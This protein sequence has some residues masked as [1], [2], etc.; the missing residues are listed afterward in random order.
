MFALWKKSCDK[1]RQHIKKQRHHFVDKSLSRQSYDFSRSHVQMW[2]LD[3]KEG[4]ALKNWCF[5]TEG[6]E[7]TL[8]IPWTARRSNQSTL[9]EINHEYLLKGLMQKLKLQHFGHLM[10]RANW[11]EKKLMLGN[12]EGRRRRGWQKMRW[13]DG[14]ID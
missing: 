3:H 10:Q 4:W 9:K 11:L 2:D 12:I 6:L 14:I 1:P 8:R 13:L 5:W 7:K